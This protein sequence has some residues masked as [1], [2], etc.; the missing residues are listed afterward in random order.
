MGNII[1]KSLTAVGVVCCLLISSG[2]NDENPEIIS[3]IKSSSFYTGDF[4]VEWNNDTSGSAF[5]NITNTSSNGRSLWSTLPGASFIRAQKADIEVTENRGSFIVNEEV[6]TSCLHQ[7]VDSI[8]SNTNGVI[9]K[10]RLGDANGN[11]RVEYTITFK[12]VSNG[13]L[14]F[15]LKVED[16][17]FN[18]VFLIF[19]SSQEEKFFGFGEQFTYLNLKG[20]EVPILSQEGGVGRGREPITSAVNLVS[21][22]SGGNAYTSYISIPHYIT[23]MNRSV[24]LETTEYAV[25]N[26]KKNDEVSI[27][28]HS[29]KMIGRILQGNSALDL[30]EKYTE[31]SGRMK[32]LPEW[33]NTGAVI[34]LQ[35]GTD[36]VYEK[37]EMLKNFDTPIAA[38]WLQD[39]VGKRKTSIGSQL[40]WNWELDRSEDAYP[41]WEQLLSDLLV[42][43]IRVMG[44]INTFL[45]DPSEKGSFERNLYQEA[46]DNGY[47][48]KTETGDPYLI[49]N[50][51][52]DSALVDLSNEDA[53]TW[54]KNV[55]KD[56]MIA[57]GFSGWMA[58]FSEA[59]PF[60]S[61]IE[62]GDAASYHNKYTEE[63]AL[64]NKEAIAEAG[65]EDEIVF[66]SRAGYTKSPGYCTLFWEG[67][68]MVTWDEH[69][70]FQSAIKGLVSGGFS[71]LSLNHSDIGGYTSYSI[72]GAS[73]FQREK[74][75]FL[76]WTETS[77]FSAVYRTHEGNEPE[78][79]YQFYSDAD[80]LTQF[81]RFAKVYA[82]LSSYRETLMQEA[83]EKGYPIVRHPFLHFPEDNNTYDLNKQFMLG[84]EFMIAPVFDKKGTQVSIYL[85]AG[86]WVHLWSGEV[87]GSETTGQWYTI[88]APVGE[89]AVFYKNGSTEGE[90]VTANLREMGLIE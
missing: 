52:F 58:D 67:D 66:F 73:I 88:S 24:F 37:L 71:G 68:Q 8:Y 6:N 32:P 64:L 50:T 11:N 45:V 2:C 29:N 61:V 26:M 47:L 51:S 3:N 18:E 87:Y 72:N 42:D 63:W 27:K 89:P 90:N 60:D 57:L 84:S 10:G 36:E 41:G 9:F 19:S 17:S 81:S 30:I 15:N 5:V 65:M 22:G 21:P 55:I 44:Y 33:L 74:S 14:Q 70:G 62:S 31:F 1:L 35:G 13:H 83:Y 77:A 76:R 40:W 48:V 43:D 28:L 80:T 82:A 59:L 86:K 7:V 34:G 25:F 49:T 4:T 53:R 46:I 12:Q 54:L 20:H 23:S 38:F 69:D 75:L 16:S 39:W 56:N 78:K 79:N 85:P